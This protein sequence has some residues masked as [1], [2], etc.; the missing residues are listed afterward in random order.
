MQEPRIKGFVPGEIQGLFLAFQCGMG[1][2]PEGMEPAVMPTRCRTHAVP[3]HREPQSW[4]RPP[5]PPCEVHDAM[6]LLYLVAAAVHP[7]RQQLH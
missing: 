2:K 5:L 3:E 1:L 6:S 7:L 4:A